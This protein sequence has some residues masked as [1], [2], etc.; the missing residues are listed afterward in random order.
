MGVPGAT[1]AGGQRRIVTS[2]APQAR[3]VLVVASKV[4]EFI[5][6]KAE[7]NT[8]QA[9]MDILSDIVRAHCEDAIQRAREEGR[10]TVLDRDI[11]FP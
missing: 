1:V 4:K 5:R 10:K 11:K 3:E 9:V 7:M 8:S 2:S 6:G